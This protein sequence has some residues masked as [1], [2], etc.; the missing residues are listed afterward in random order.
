MADLSLPDF[1]ASLSNKKYKKSLTNF[2]GMFPRYQAYLLK[3]SAAQTLI[4]GNILSGGLDAFRQDSLVLKTEKLYEDI[5]KYRFPDGTVKWFFFNNPVDIVRSAVIDDVNNQ[6]FMTGLGPLRVFDASTLENKLT[7]TVDDTNSY[8]AG[9][10]APAKPVLS[11]YTDSINATL[12]TALAIADTSMKTVK[13]TLPKVWPTVSGVAT[14]KL[15]ITDG[16]NTE[17][18]KATALDK[19]NA[20]YDLF[21]ITRAQD[22]TTAKAFAIA[23]TTINI[24]Y[25][26]VKASRTY[27]IAY[28]RTWSSGKLDNGPL[29][30]VA[31]TADKLTYVDLLEN[32]KARLSGIVKDPVDLEH[33][34]NVYIYRSA[35]QTNGT[36]SWRLVQTFST[37]TGAILPT[38]V[39]YNTGNGTY[40]FTDDVLDEDLG[41]APEST[42]WSCPEKLEGIVSLRN[43]IFAAFYKNTVY[44]SVAYQGHAW[45]LSYAIPLDFDI[46]GLGCFGN[47]LVI[48]TTASTFLCVVSNPANTI[49]IPLQEANACISKKSIVSL[50]ESVIYATEFGLVRITNN[51]VQQLTTSIFSERSWRNYNPATITACGWQG[52]YLM[53]FESEK[54]PYS[55]CVI[56][57][58]ELTTGILGLSQQISCLRV[59]DTGTSVFIQYMHPIL[60]SPCIFSFATNISLKRIYRW[61]SKKF[62]DTTG[63]F[64]MSASKVNFYKDSTV[65]ET[66]TFEYLQGS[67]AFNAPYVNLYS[68]N[69]DAS[70]NQYI[71]TTLG[72]QWCKFT[73]YVNDEYKV[74]LYVK[75]N[76]PFRLPAGFRGDSMY[77]EIVSTEPISRVQLAASI[78]ELE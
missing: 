71:Q 34:Q 38:S 77:V 68:L 36:A 5:Y 17:I 28:A 14:L 10:S 21:T 57:F 3:D 33:A 41:D 48:C 54:V 73:Y 44:F 78:G 70:T 13:L 1:L 45:P 52:K 46:V 11:V 56:D 66:K 67:G 51:G 53:F 20:S 43:G 37:K 59:D 4:D 58:N 24:V 39:T 69:G 15:K 60:R 35:V 74:S 22:G 76:K 64:T 55:G 62:I 63:L 9:I 32:Q 25:E 30:D 65:L 40:T 29:S 2:L 50:Q 72:Q 61:V 23:N 75:D 8:K 12:Q 27:C 18:V 19:T 42:Y 26:T 16:T 6:T 31:E 49:L 7:T 47:T